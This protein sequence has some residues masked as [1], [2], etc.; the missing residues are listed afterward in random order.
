MASCAACLVLPTGATTFMTYSASRTIE[1]TQ[2]DTGAPQST[3]AYLELDAMEYRDPGDPDNP[4]PTPIVIGAGTGASPVVLNVED[5]FD[6][7][8]ASARIDLGPGTSVADF[9]AAYGT[10]PYTFEMTGGQGNLRMRSFA[11]EMPM[12][13][14]P[15]SDWAGGA[16]QLLADQG[17]TL[18]FDPF[19]SQFNDSTFNSNWSDTA[20]IVLLDS[21][22]S[23]ILNSGSL[24]AVTGSF[25][26]PADTLAP[27]ETV[28][29]LLSFERFHEDISYDETSPSNIV[30]F[31]ESVSTLLQT[32]FEIRA[33]PEPSSSAL[34]TLGITM[35]CLF[36]SRLR[37][38]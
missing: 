31:N 30:N 36:R 34:L 22:G 21:N 13:T 4:T 8:G 10:R 6:S 25:L 29:G 2:R 26:I 38:R 18:T 33:V 16:I 9:E 23:S 27:G 14:N 15:A 19:A 20:R 17:F 24:N 12:L 32:S 28:T 1:F 37:G 3:R 11:D 35:C 7:A 5:G